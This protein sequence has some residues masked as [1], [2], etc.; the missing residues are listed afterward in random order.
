MNPPIYIS[1]VKIRQ[2]GTQQER[3]HGGFALEF[4]S[5]ESH[6]YFKCAGNEETR[7]RLAK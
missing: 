5:Q 7:G 3:L 6:I 1:S 2:R 4:V